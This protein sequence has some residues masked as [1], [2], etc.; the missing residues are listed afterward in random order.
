MD[1]SVLSF[2]MNRLHLTHTA[3]ALPASSPTLYALAPKSE[4]HLPS[5]QPLLHSF[6]KHPAVGY[7][8]PSRHSF[9]PSFEG[10]LATKSFT[11]PTCR[12]T[13]RFFGFWWKLSS[14]NSFRMHTSRLRVCNPFR[15]AHIQKTGG[16]DVYLCQTVGKPAATRRARS[17]VRL[18]GAKDVT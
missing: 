5:F 4:A 18:R 3:A 1:S 12:Q 7:E 10:S 9:T 11:F 15:N 8:L 14:R 6:L 16:G 13:P 17:I 2:T